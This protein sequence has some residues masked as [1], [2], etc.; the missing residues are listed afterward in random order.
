M[1]D[2][3]GRHSERNLRMAFLRD[4]LQEAKLVRPDYSKRY[5]QDF[6]REGFTQVV[7]RANV[8]ADPE[9]QVLDGNLYMI[10]QLLS[11]DNPLFRISHPNCECKFEAYG[12]SSKTTS[13]PP[14]TTGPVTGPGLGIG[15]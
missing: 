13:P 8:A 11:L 4:I 10:D 9:C 14:S 1:F 12:P 6:Q 2:I 3:I 5:L 15:I 7:F